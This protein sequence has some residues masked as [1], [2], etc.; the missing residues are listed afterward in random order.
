[1]CAKALT[2]ICVFD[3]HHAR[4][5]VGVR[6]DSLVVRNFEG[7]GVTGVG[8]RGLVVD[9]VRAENNARYGVTRFASSGG[10]FI[11]N[12]ATGSADAG[13]YIGD[14]PR[15]NLFIA[16]NDVRNNG[17]GILAR[18]A[19]HVSIEY[20][21][22]SN[23]CIG[24]FIWWLPGVAGDGDIRFNTSRHNNK[25]C[26]RGEE[27]PFNYSGSGIALM[28]AHNVVVGNNA[29]L[30]NRGF[31][32]VSGG[33]V[34]SGKRFGGPPSAANIIQNNS[35]FGNAPADII[36]RSS[37]QNTFRFN[38]CDTSRPSGLC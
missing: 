38:H 35:A 31:T 30:N 17:F 2:G 28:G 23:N 22:A 8:T 19:Q 7:D 16:G 10:A 6:V 36:N 29:V 27:I 4:T 33:I 24:I 15:A 25:F 5:I 32:P 37:G 11:N 20:N 26:K 12:V 14:S 18:N 34:V 1:V 9:N 21:D 3:P 13:I